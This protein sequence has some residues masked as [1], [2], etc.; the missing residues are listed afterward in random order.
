MH[1]KLTL[2]TIALL[3][4]AVDISLELAKSMFA[5]MLLM[6]WYLCGDILLHALAGKVWDRRMRVSI[7]KFVESI[8]N[9]NREPYLV[10][11][12][13]T[14]DF[15]NKVII[16]Y[17]CSDDQDFFQRSY[18]CNNCYIDTYYKPP[19]VNPLFFENINAWNTT[20][21]KQ[22]F[23]GNNNTWNGNKLHVCLLPAIINILQLPYSRSRLIMHTQYG[24]YHLAVKHIAEFKISFVDVEI[25]HT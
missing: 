1:E 9:I 15:K 19:K 3:A 13:I 7:V 10:S 17:L 2:N 6:H 20:Q 4:E 14:M 16:P 12:N 21:M 22:V 24:E 18:W 25:A 5:K 23:F 11:H 8:E